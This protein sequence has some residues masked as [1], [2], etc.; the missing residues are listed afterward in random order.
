M[1]QELRLWI[2]FPRFESFLVMTVIILGLLDRVKNLF[3]YCREIRREINENDITK[4]CHAI[5]LLWV[6][7]FFFFFSGFLRLLYTFNNAI[8]YGI[9]TRCY[10]LFSDLSCSSATMISTWLW[11]LNT[12]RLKV[13]L[14]T[15]KNVTMKWRYVRSVKYVPGIYLDYRERTK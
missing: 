1:S 9:G 15:W 11:R 6:S 3:R 8:V 12:R 4:R 2:V 10:S 7:Y 5:V 13:S 14:I